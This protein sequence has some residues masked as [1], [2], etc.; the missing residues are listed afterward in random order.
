MCIRDRRWVGEQA[1]MLVARALP[2][3]PKCFRANLPSIST[4]SFR[5]D[6]FRPVLEMRAVDLPATLHYGRVPSPSAPQLEGRFVPRRV[7]PGSGR[8]SGA[9]ADR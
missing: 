5:E 2:F 6:K 1:G 7:R 9:Q 8:V 4:D 3:S